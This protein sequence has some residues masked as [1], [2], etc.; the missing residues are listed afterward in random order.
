MR[1]KKFLQALAVIPAI[2][3]LSGCENWVLPNFDGGVL[4][5]DIHDIRAAEVMDGVKCAMVAFMNEREQ[6][7]YLQREADPDGR[8][9]NQETENGTNGF[10][11]QPN[12]LHVTKAIAAH[13]C[14][15]RNYF[16]NGKACVP[17]HCEQESQH[18]LG[19]TLWDYQ[20]DKTSKGATQCKAIPDYS[21]FALDHTQS[22][23]I[24]LTLMATNNGSVAYNRI[25][26]NKL[27]PRHVFLAPGN[28]ATGAP[29]PGFTTTL[30]GTAMVDLTAVMPQSIHGY[31][32][33]EAAVDINPAL[34]SFR[35]FRDDIPQKKE[36]ERIAN[37]LSSN[38]ELQIAS[39]TNIQSTQEEEKVDQK[40]KAERENASLVNQ[41]LAARDDFIA[42][43]N[44]ASEEN[45][46][47]KGEA[48]VQ[49][50]KLVMD[51][52][53]PPVDPK[54]NPRLL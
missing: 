24:E 45:I 48:G 1:S 38:D 46:G 13:K 35:L 4:N 51:Y 21:R 47:L 26:A 20:A 19:V 39:F 25:D 5:P 33:A 43:I 29:F 22:A 31:E 10:V 54:K 27:D 30:K 28:S 40:D 12:A 52:K 18:P 14:L 32:Q 49:Y 11:Y 50:A 2:F 36:I 15:D 17:T 16:W 8:I 23:S 41:F 42:L 6:Q 53:L 34:P 9:K 3:T 7:L 44:N 37:L